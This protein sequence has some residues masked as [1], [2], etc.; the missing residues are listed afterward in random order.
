MT[1]LY[2][3]FSEKQKEANNQYYIYL[4]TSGQKVIVTEVKKQPEKNE[5]FD[6][7]L[8]LGEVS[9]FVSNVK[10]ESTWILDWPTKRE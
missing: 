4:D 6:D 8:V 10:T 9:K 5:N 3:L 2:G 1:K 7:C